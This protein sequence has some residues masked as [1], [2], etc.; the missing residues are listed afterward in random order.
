M[1]WLSKALLGVLF[2]LMA[3]CTALATSFEAVAFQAQDGVLVHADLYASK[4]GFDGPVMVLFHQAG[5]NAAEY[6]TIAPRLLRL[7][8]TVVAVDQRSGGRMFGKNNRTVAGLMG[9]TADFN[10]AF[11][12]LQAA[13]EWVAAQGQPTSVVVWG[14]SYSAAS[15]FR[16][17]SLRPD[18]DAVLAFSPGEFLGSEHNVG[19]YAALVK[20][21]TYVTAGEG[22]E[23]LEARVIFDAVASAQKT[24]HRPEAGVHGASTLRADRNPSGAAQNWVSVQA[25]LLRH[26]KGL[27]SPSAP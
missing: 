11:A 7:G 17:A 15:V 4:K 20:V 14:S 22:G 23:V 5:A 13:V 6:E 27:R 10:E 3:P 12:D 16:L 18:V 8:A 26:V 24:F 25:F 2:V 19:G 1:L 21:P 9:R